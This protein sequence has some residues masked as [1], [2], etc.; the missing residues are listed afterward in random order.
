MTKNQSQKLHTITAR[1]AQNGVL[2]ALAAAFSFLESLIP[3]P[4]G[5]RLGLSG[6]ITL[7]GIFILT[8]ADAAA[9]LLLKSLF[10]LITRG[11]SAG[12]LSLSGG[13]LSLAGM[14]LLAK[15][16]ASLLTTSSMGGL[17]HNLG[18][19]LAAMLLTGSEGLFYLL[20]ML[21]ISGILAGS[22]TAW[23]FHLLL[24]RLPDRFLSSESIQRKTTKGST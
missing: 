8:P 4:Y 19:M 10:V 1:L 21:T 12:L 16:G 2:L 13:L 22:A 14:L 7:Y 9:I 17:L 18:Q 24:R 20:P 23:I 6:I 5:I 11:V 15:M 3:L